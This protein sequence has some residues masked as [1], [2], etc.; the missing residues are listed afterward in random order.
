MYKFYWIDKT[1]DFRILLKF[2]TA[3]RK[4]QP[5]KSSLRISN[6]FISWVTLLT[7]CKTFLQKIVRFLSLMRATK[8][9]V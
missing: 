5:T 1:D 8:E 4:Q 7:Q 6:K 2:G 3:D 9:N